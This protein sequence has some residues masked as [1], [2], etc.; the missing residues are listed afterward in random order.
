ML[1][2]Y[3]TDGA[4]TD[5]NTYWGYDLNLLLLSHGLAYA[6]ICC[7]TLHDD[8][9]FSTLLAPLQWRHNERYGVSNHRHLH[10]LLNRLFRRWSKNSSKLHVTGLCERNPPVTGGF[11]SQRASDA[12]NV[13]ISLRHNYCGETTSDRSFPLQKN[14]NAS[15][16]YPSMFDDAWGLFY[17]HRL[18][19]I[20]AWISNYIHYKVRDEITYPFLN[21]N[22]ATSQYLSQGYPRSMSP[23]DITRPQWVNMNMYALFA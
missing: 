11:P 1:R 21:F 2:V 7:S 22:G 5:L 9:I 13:S 19:L 15:L 10:C 8:V 18:T 3:S 16:R 4:L 23:Y 17:L 20:P 14:T 12:E 6:H